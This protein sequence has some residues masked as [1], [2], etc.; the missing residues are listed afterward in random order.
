MTIGLMRHRLY[1]ADAT[2]SRWV[3]YGAMTFCLLAIFAETEKA[4]E[5]MGERWFG[6]ELGAPAPLRP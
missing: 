2:I 1:D 3:A 5:L 4:F 6:A